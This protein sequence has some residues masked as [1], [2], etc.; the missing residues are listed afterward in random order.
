MPSRPTD[1]DKS[2]AGTITAKIIIRSVASAARFFRVG[3]TAVIFVCIGLKTIANVAAHRIGS[4]K[5][6]IIAKKA[7]L[8]AINIEK[9]KAL[10]TKIP[11][12]NYG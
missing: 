9:K 1:S 5:G 2:S 6:E 7:K 12:L 3:N 4:K 8:A 11:Y 10:C